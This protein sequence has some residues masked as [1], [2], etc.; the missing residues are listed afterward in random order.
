MREFITALDFLD[1]LD[2]SP[3]R[4]R[5]NPKRRSIAALQGLHE[6][7]D[8]SELGFFEVKHALDEL[9]AEC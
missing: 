4:L 3:R 9:F 8:T 5:R 7:L 1:A 2:D 6:C